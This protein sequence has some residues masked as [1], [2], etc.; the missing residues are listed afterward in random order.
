MAHLGV[1]KNMVRAIRHWCLT[2]QMI[3]RESASR[4]S[5]ARSYRPTELGR[6]IFLSDRGWDP[7]L[8]DVGTLWAVH[9]L[10]TTN[11]S[12]ATTW[13][14]V[15]DLYHHSEFTRDRMEHSLFEFAHSI[16]GT[17][18]TKATI[19]RDMDVFLRT[20]I[21]SRSASAEIP[22]DS[23]SCPLI[24]LGLL[25]HTTEPG[26]FCLNRGPKE[27]L[28]DLVLAWAL[29]EYVARQPQ[30]RTFSFEDLAYAPG[31][32]GRVFQLDEFSLG[33]R[34]ERIPKYTRK[35]W[36]FSETAGLRQL[37]VSRPVDGRILLEKYYAA[38]TR[39]RKRK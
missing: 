10:I 25:Q 13:H 37:V 14:F 19:K 21:S 27:T 32:P 15:F 24:E 22:E 11:T 17:R 29:A 36:S 35:A 31:S 5:R 8:E 39:S 28:P 38:G 33:A 12:A 6:R 26:S 1:G 23:L 9:W 34:L 30:L 16:H 7:F 20:Y 3:E 18:A 4:G 2:S